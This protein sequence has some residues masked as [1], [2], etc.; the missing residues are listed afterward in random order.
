MILIVSLLTFKKLKKQTYRNCFLI[1]FG[2]LVKMKKDHDL[3]LILRNHENIALNY[4]YI[5]VS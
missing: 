5:Y 2:K 4:K 1:N 3:S